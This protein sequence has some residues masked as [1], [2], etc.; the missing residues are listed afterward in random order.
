MSGRWVRLYLDPKHRRLGLYHLTDG[1]GGTL[2]GFALNGRA[3]EGVPTTPSSK[4]R[5]CVQV[6]EA[7]THDERSSA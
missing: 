5:F 3:V 4:C 1:N 2:C 6:T 7:A